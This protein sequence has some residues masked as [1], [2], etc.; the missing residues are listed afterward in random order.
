MVFCGVWA[1]FYNIGLL[2]KVY[3]IPPIIDGIVTLMYVIFLY[4]EYQLEQI[5]KT[6][7]KSKRCIMILLKVAL[8]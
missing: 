7:E 5:Y 8:G 2:E 6:S 3:N 4:N 1:D